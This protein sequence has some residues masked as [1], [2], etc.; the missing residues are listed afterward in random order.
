MEDAVLD[1]SVQQ[2][3]GLYA[4]LLV[5]SSQHLEHHVNCD[6]SLSTIQL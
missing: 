6:T 2:R 4:T 1:T 5:P 3:A